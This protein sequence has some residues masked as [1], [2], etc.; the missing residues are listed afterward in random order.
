MATYYCANWGNDANDGL[1][2]AKAKRTIAGIVATAPAASIIEIEGFYNQYQSGATNYTWDGKG[3]CV[4]DGSFLAQATFSLGII[5]NAIL[6]NWNSPEPNTASN[7]N[8]NLIIKNSEGANTNNLRGIINCLYICKTNYSKID[9]TETRP[10]YGNTFYSNSVSN[11]FVFST[12]GAVK[13]FDNSYDNIFANWQIDCRLSK[14]GSYFLFL[15]C[16]FKFTI[17]GLGADETIYA[18]PTGADDDAKIQNLRDRMAI[19]YGGSASSYLI[20]CKY[21]SGS[22]TDIFINPSKEN[23]YLVEGCLAASMNFNGLYI[24]SRPEGR[25]NDYNTNYSGIVN[26]DANGK[27]IDQTI[28]ASAT[29]AI[30]DLGKVRKILKLEALGYRSIRNGVEMNTAINLGPQINEGANVLTNNKSYRVEGE[31]IIMDNGAA[32][33]YNV[34]DRFLAIDEGGGAGLG[35]DSATNIGFVR[36]IDITKPR[37]IKIKCSKISSDLS[38]LAHVNGF[39]TLDLASTPM[40]NI[41]LNGEPTYGN[42]D[43]G[44]NAG[45]AVPLYARYIQDLPVIKTNQL[46]A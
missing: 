3:N 12:V 32:T 31:P 13:R 42:L 39:I 15:N 30:I 38:S 24:G 36:E 40:V 10:F 23:F 45:S 44:Y 1:S 6:Q 33:N 37:A 16:K 14:I 34:D 25:K 18:Y 19:V 8:E 26:I 9:N 46:P 22:E 29:G 20:G 28:D 21:Y 17:G 41:N 27:I 5:K 4:L 11:T 43:D 7:N 2:R 35:F